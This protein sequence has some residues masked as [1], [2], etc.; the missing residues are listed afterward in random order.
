[1]VPQIVGVGDVSWCKARPETVTEWGCS[2][3]LCLPCVC[4]EAELNL[5]FTVESE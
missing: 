2:D 1:M 4:I 3:V 5:K